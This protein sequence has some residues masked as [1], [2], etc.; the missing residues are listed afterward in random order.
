MQRNYSAE[1][2]SDNGSM[3]EAAHKVAIVLSI[4]FLADGLF[5]AWALHAG[6]YA[7]L[8]Y[9][10]FGL[11]PLFLPATVAGL[12]LV[13]IYVRGFRRFSWKP[14]RAEWLFFFL[15]STSV[16]TKVIGQLLWG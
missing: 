7:G 15:I 3:R 12:V 13:G 6:G 1:R 8:P 14:R 4:M 10:F 9:V 2:Q 16:A 5:M 11:I